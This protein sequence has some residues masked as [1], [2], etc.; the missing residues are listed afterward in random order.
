MTV[1]TTVDILIDAYDGLLLDAYG[2][3][4]DKAGALPGAVELIEELNFVGKPYLIVTNSASR[5]AETHSEEFAAVGLSV[6]PGRVLSSGMLLPPHFDAYGL[7]GARC[8]VLGTEASRDYV[9]AAGGIAVDMTSECDAQVLVIADQ[10]GFDCLAGMN[11][12]LSLLLRRLDAGQDLHLILCNP[13]LIYP[14]AAGRYGFTAGGLAAMLESVIEQRYP[15]AGIGFERLG[16]PNAPIF[17]EAERRIGRGRLVMVG[18]QLATDILGAS[19]AGMD[20]ALVRTG[21]APAG[22]S[23]ALGVEPTWQLSGLDAWHH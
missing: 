14:V 18:D 5:S 13:D 6:P 19:R 1:E 20:S 2:V 16:K 3:L 23:N 7:V 8:L 11:A 4:V 12:A 15:R 9:A 17:A 22:A 21:L 10:A